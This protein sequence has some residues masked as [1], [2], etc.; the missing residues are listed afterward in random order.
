[1]NNIRTYAMISASVL[2]AIGIVGF[3]FNEQFSIPVYILLTN[4][5]IGLWGM[6]V[7]F[8]KSKK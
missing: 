7:I 4:L 1:M 5:C 8:G 6:F 2:L 3:A